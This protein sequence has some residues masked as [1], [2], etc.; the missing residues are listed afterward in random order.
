MMEPGRSNIVKGD[1]LAS[2]DPSAVVSAVRT[3]EEMLDCESRRVEVAA[4][5][6]IL[7]LSNR[8][9]KDDLKARVSLL[10]SRCRSALRRG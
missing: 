5:R 6:T 7:E 10:E 9:I 1:P 4:A 2:I 3:L 8:F